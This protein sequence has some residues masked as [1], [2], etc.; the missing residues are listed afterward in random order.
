MCQT[1]IAVNPIMKSRKVACNHLKY[2]VSGS[3]TANPLTRGWVGSSMHV[4]QDVSGRP[5]SKFQK[6]MDRVYLPICRLPKVCAWKVAYQN[7]V[8]C[9]VQNWQLW[10]CWKAI[11]SWPKCHTTVHTPSGRQEVC[12]C[13]PA[14]W[15]VQPR[16]RHCPFRTVS[17]SPVS[18]DFLTVWDLD[19]GRPYWLSSPQSGKLLSTPE[20]GNEL[21]KPIPES[22]C[23]NPIVY[24]AKANIIWL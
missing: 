10:N 5:P 12:V 7:S 16:V 8:L 13:W 15:P 22:P 14:V 4:H 19:S 23:E 9:T 1:C 18:C 6:E 21:G 2:M 11:G 3:C 24:W 17:H 20:L